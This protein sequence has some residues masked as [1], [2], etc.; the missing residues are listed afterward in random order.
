[1][2]TL[3]NNENRIILSK[4]TYFIIDNK[5]APIIKIG[6]NFYCISLQTID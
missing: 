4:D 5:K 3:K 6:A 2:E 1:M